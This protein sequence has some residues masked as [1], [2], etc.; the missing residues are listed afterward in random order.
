MYGYE[1][2]IAEMEQ[3]HAAWLQL[4]DQSA[5]RLEEA[6]L[7]LP[8]PQNVK[9]YAYLQGLTRFHNSLLALRLLVVSGFSEEAAGLLRHMTEAAAMVR[10]ISMSGD[11]QVWPLVEKAGSVPWDPA[12][13]AKP[14]GVPNP[15]T[16]AEQEDW[17]PPI[18]PS[19]F[20]AT[21][22][23]SKGCRLAELLLETLPE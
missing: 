2:T 13:A 11:S 12:D 18:G 14:D 9:A 23:L 8:V 16:L 21:D 22:L 19:P 4:L 3:R 20:D 7:E 6:L 10:Y 5:D 15:R 1:E 17:F